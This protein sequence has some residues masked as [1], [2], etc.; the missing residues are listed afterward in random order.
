[1]HIAVYRVA[2]RRR[3]LLQ[4]LLLIL[5]LPVYTAGMA[6]LYSFILFVLMAQPVTQ[7][8]YS[9]LVAVLATPTEWPIDEP[10]WWAVFVI[11]SAVLAITQTLFLI[12]TWVIKQPRGG[13][14]RSLR[15]S[16]IMA[17]FVAMVL[18][19]GLAA[20][21]LGLVQLIVSNI[22][23][24]SRDPA[25]ANLPELMSIAFV[26]LM[27]FSWIFF[28]ALL[29]VFARRRH[30]E[31]ALS[32]D[33]RRPLGGNDCRGAGRAAAGH[34]DSQADTLLLRHRQFLDAGCVSVGAPV[35]DWPGNCDCIDEQAP[36]AVVGHALRAMRIRKGAFACLARIARSAGLDGE[37]RGR[38]MPQAAWRLIGDR[39]ASGRSTGLEPATLGTTTR[40]STN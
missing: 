27:A 7:Q 22:Q 35:V 2:M 34:H 30:G 33:S 20:G 36:P 1:V 13:H 32:E 4:I 31:H 37:S 14:A 10:T 15:V 6:W 29:I 21:A 12:P 18:T 17:G 25:D 38:A 9:E 24:N 8:E 11:P 39:C 5:L 16:L 26:L 23:G 40:C 19:Y 28:S 3:W